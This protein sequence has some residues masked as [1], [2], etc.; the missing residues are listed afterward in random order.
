MICEFEFEKN[1]T[2][3]FIFLLLQLPLFSQ[4]MAPK[5]SKNNHFVNPVSH[6][7][8]FLL[9][10]ATFLVNEMWRVSESRN[11]PTLSCYQET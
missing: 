1:I 2:F 9:C 11:L 3:S 6:F 8:S 10:M 7:D 5:F 4:I